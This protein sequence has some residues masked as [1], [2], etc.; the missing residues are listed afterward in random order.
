MGI[1]NLISSYKYQACTVSITQF[2]EEEGGDEDFLRR[3]LL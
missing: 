1:S 3:D 2:K